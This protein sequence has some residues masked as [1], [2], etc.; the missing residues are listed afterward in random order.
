MRLSA[1][2]VLPFLLGGLGYPQGVSGHSGSTG[3][4]VSKI[5]EA[6]E[7]MHCI[8]LAD[9]LSDFPPLQ[10][11]TSFDIGLRHDRKTYPG[12]DIV[13]V[14][15]FESQTRGNAFELVKETKGAHRNY[16]FTN[17]GS[18]ILGKKETRWLNEILGGNWTHDYIEG[19]VRKIARG[20]RQRVELKT[21]LRSNLNATCTYYSL[22]DDAPRH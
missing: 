16:H 11:A 12:Q 14:A 1:V 4:A 9:L 7:I 13:I 18:F 3:P 5:N 22:P 8:H 15:V 20:A 21:A 17:N 10:K 19:N 6:A 2:F